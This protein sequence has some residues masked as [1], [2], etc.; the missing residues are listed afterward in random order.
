MTKSGGPVLI[1]EERDWSEEL[2]PFMRRT[3]NVASR[4]LLRTA[5]PEVRAIVSKLKGVERDCLVERLGPKA[6]Q[7]GEE[8]WWVKVD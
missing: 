2:L 6:W 7:G 8:M 1:T 5:R 3:E 4:F